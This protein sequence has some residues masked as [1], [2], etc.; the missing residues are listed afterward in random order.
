[1]LFNYKAVTK[2]GEEREGSIDGSSIDN[3]ILTLQKQ[4]LVIVEIKP[5]IEASKPRGKLSLFGGVKLK[6]VVVLS[7]QLSTLISAN[8]PILT[9][10]RLVASETESPALQKIL[11][12]VVDDVQGGT[13][14]STA[15]GKH[16]DAFSPFY[17]S[18]VK[19]SEESGRLPETLKFLA[20]YLERSYKLTQKAKNALVYPIFV[21]VVFALVMILMLV[22]V[23]PQLSAILLE[24]GQKIPIFTRVIISSSQFL[25][26]YGVLLLFLVIVLGIVLWQYGKTKSGKLSFDRFKLTIPYLGVLYRKIYLSRITDNLNMM[27]ESG[28]PVVRSIE[29][30]ADVVG[31]Q[32]YRD[33]LLQSAEAVKSGQ[34]LSEAFAFHSEFPS[35][36]S[37]MARI[38]EETGKLDYVLKTLSRFY[39]QEVESTIDLLVGLIEPVL[40]VVLGL[41][42][43]ILLA[44]ILLPI[45][46]LTGAL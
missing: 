7:Q 13:P 40:I 43:A 36:M 31:N 45:Y 9:T 12:E 3:A 8:V 42:V 30:S 25:V 39:T 11:T 38:G 28:I 33:A 14:I 22:L 15:L 27:L 16:P 46:S 29:V 24:A 21:I 5:S 41:G 32:V 4:D 2:T 20:E 23:I 37:Q 44:G 26:D 34:A 1:M 18:L 6:D 35:I 17:V 19:A 10:L